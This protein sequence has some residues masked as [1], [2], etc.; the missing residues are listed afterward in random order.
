MFAD[1]TWP[2]IEI[3]NHELCRNAGYQFGKTSDG[4][5]SSLKFFEEFKARESLKLYEAVDALRELHRMAPFLFLNGN[6]FCEIGRE[7]VLEY[8]P[9]ANASIAEILSVVGHH[10]AGKEILSSDNLREILT[11]K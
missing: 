1:V 3:T 7:L 2:E 10:I 9:S 8:P 4:F 6:T 5:S 11:T